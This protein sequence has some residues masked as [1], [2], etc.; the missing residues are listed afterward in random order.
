MSNSYSLRDTIVPNS[1]QLNADQLLAGPMTITVRDVRVTVGDQPVSI[2]YAGDNGRPY[3]PNK[4]M[5]K[6]LIYAWG[7]DER[8]WPGRCL[9]LYN[10]PD[11]KFGGDKVGGIK[12]SHLTDIPGQLVMSLNSTKG[13]KSTITINPLDLSALAAAAA[14]G[15]KALQSAWAAMHADLRAAMGNCPEGIKEIARSAAAP[16]TEE[17]AQ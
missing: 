3:K 17:P 5:R 16:K 14:G 4:T 2:F 12:I 9:T 13:K 10:D 7:D 11:V 8:T 6:A 15:M 1:N